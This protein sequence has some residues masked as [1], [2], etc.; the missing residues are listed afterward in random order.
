MI[1]PE[2]EIYAMNMLDWIKFFAIVIPIVALMGWGIYME[3]TGYCISDYTC[4]A[5][6]TPKAFRH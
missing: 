6:I 2:Q 1:I 5:N 4:T 3:Y